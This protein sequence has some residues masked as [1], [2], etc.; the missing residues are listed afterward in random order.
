MIDDVVSIISGLKFTNPWWLFLLPILATL[1]GWKRI[2]AR[3]RQ[4]GVLFPGIGRLRREGLAVNPLKGTFPAALRWLAL[5]A[6]VL[7]LAGPRAPVQPSAMT[8][9]GIDIMLALD[10]SESMRQRDFDGKSRFDAARDA[11]R[12]F[13]DNRKA[14]RIGLLVFSG[15]SFTRCPLTLDHEVLDRLV[16]TVEPGFIQEQGT[17]IGTAVLTATNR[18]E[19]SESKEKVLVLI[20]DGENNSGEVAPGTAARLAA[21]KGVRIY[22]VFAGKTGAVLP[23]ETTTVAVSPRPGREELAEVSRVSGG[24]MFTAD[25]PL[26][27]SRTFKDIDRLEKT[28]LQGSRS[29]RTAELYPWM[30]MAAGVMLV[31]EL[32][33]SS[34]RFM[35]IP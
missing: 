9:S 12:E 19:A 15:R 10:I 6:G 4:P 31:L 8:S 1:D 16:D 23:A 11:A 2:I 27:M 13:I 35:R 18:L 21:G 30:L 3:R 22:T 26:G 20:T 33:L 29:G 5:S 24:R 25:D 28:R 34:T 17:A 7:A 14:D 32:G